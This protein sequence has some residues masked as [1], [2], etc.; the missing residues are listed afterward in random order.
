MDKSS[1]S[2][3]KLITFALVTTFVTYA[4]RISSL[5]PTQISSPP[6][7]PYPIQ[8]TVTIYP[9][10][11]LDTEV[12]IPDML[13]TEIPHVRTEDES[14]WIQSPAPGEKVSDELLVQGI[15]DPTFEQNLGIRL[16]DENSKE[17]FR[18][19]TVIQSEAGTPG[20]FSTTIDIADIPTQPATLQ[21]FSS[22]PKDGSI[23]H[24]SSV[25]V[26]LN[27]GD[28]SNP[29]TSSID[30]RISITGITQPSSSADHAVVITGSSWGAF[31][32]TLNYA[33][34]GESSGNTPDLICG[35]M[36]NR[37][38]IGVVTTD[39]IEMGLPGNFE[40]SLTNTNTFP[41]SATI[42]VYSV[43]PMNGAIDHAASRNV[44]QQ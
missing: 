34:C 1:L 43:S 15:A 6:P 26:N 14:I 23:T 4:C 10:I 17:L 41:R 19:N 16:V 32:N 22:S 36:E 30:E 7:T 31:E 12:T 27:S 24:L 40:I 9:T 20:E 2:N 13:F 8:P 18:G 25:V 28:I 21:V 42:V 3:H 38:I 39:A 33:V 11:A 35:S 29:N 44:F 5:P 37:I